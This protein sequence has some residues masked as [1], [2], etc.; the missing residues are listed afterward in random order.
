MKYKNILKASLAALLGL[1]TL[2]GCVNKEWN[3]ITELNL[4]RCLVPGNL[5]V[6]VDPSAGDV[7]TF[8]WSLKHSSQERTRAVLS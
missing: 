8:D 6:R 5:A 7:V 3:E 2:S 1:A 4:A